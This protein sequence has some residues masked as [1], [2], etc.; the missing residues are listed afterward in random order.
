MEVVGQR[1]NRLS[2][3]CESILTAA[4]V[5]GCQFEFGVL[6]P[7]NEEIT[8]IALLESMDA[9]RG[10]V[11]QF[12]HALV[13]Q[14]LREQLSISRRVRLHA[15]TGETLETLHG[16]RLGDHAAKLAFHFAEAAPVAGA[17]SLVKYALLAEDR[18]L[19]AHV[20]EE[21][22]E[23][24]M[25]ALKSKDINVEGAIP[26]TDAEEAVLLF[27]RGR[28]QAAEGRR[29]LDAAFTS[30]SRAFDFYADTNDVSQAIA[31]AE[32]PLHVMQGHQGAA[33]LLARALRMGSPRL[34]R[35]RT[36]PE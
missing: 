14:T 26:A 4:A 33:D 1:L 19:A 28:T 35:S 31:I 20:H 25:R 36:P 34:A 29:G 13:Q 9:G 30:M 15:R 7:L 27:G 21:A 5:I 10:D 24:F 18:A 22:L 2:T 8:E 6:G 3:D 16:D 12:S 23:Q 11:Y 32:F 17:E